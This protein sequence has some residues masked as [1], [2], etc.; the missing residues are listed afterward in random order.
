[1]LHANGGT[2]LRVFENRARRR[3]IGTKKDMC[4]VGECR[5]LPGEG[6]RKLYCTRNVIGIKE[7]GMS[8][9]YST[10][11]SGVQAFDKNS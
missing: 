6:I 5:N 2:C 3:V 9:A 8:V 10:H 4:I 7:I 1:M 11:L